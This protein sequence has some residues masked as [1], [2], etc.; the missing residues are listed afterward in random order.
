MYYTIVSVIMIIMKYL[1]LLWKLLLVIVVTGII[2]YTALVIIVR[3]SND[4]DWT[5]DQAVL[6]VAEI[7]GN[8]VS[9]KN[10]RN[11]SYRT[12]EDYTPSYYDATF[13]LDKIKNVYFIVEPFSGY[14][15]AAHTFL[16]FEFEGDRFVAI[17]V[18]IRKEKG[19]SFSALK[20]AL[21]QYELTYVI[22]DERDVVKLR[23]NYRKDKVFVYPIKTTKEKMRA[24]FVNML[25][26][27]NELREKPEF[28]N[29]LFSNCT[30]NL[31]KH[32]NQ[33]TPGRVSWNITYLLPENSDRY[34]Y[35]VGLID[36]SL[37]F[38]ETRARHFINE[39]AE[40]Y[41]DNPDFSLKIRGR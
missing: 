3:P 31:A 18:E 32:V 25:D 1:K 23:S 20:G 13:D 36:N 28:Y 16:S 22:A 8:K 34:V 24:V 30:T 39:L 21:R 14:V 37:P 27:A 4:R 26:R 38:D 12:T 41:A 17:S 19:E 11:F 10:I 2:G 15:G 35:D 33:I 7:S 5:L 29:T 9:I 40:K 6:P